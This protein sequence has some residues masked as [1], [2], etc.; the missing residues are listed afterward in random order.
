MILPWR[1]LLREI[2]LLVR[3]WWLRTPGP[4][5]RPLSRL[6]DDGLPGFSV[7]LAP[8]APLCARTVAAR[9]NGIDLVPADSKVLVLPVNEKKS[10]LQNATEE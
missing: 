5:C 3:E 9:R 8:V 2:T 7:R 10:E 4:E 1:E 6:G